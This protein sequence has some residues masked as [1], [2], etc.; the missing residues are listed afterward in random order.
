MLEL[1]SETTKPELDVCAVRLE[2]RARQ[3]VKLVCQPSRA[4][5]WLFLGLLN[6]VDEDLV[7]ELRQPNQ[8]RPFT[9]SPV[10]TAST[11]RNGPLNLEQGQTC[12]LRF[13][14]LTTRLKQALNKLALPSSV[15]LDDLEFEPVALHWEGEYASQTN[16][17]TLLDRHFFDGNND[18]TGRPSNLFRLRFL[19]P[20][21]FRLSG[22]EL[23]LPLPELIFGSL[24]QRW[25]RFSP[26]PL[27]DDAHIFAAHN[28]KLDYARIETFASELDNQRL[29]GFVGRVTFRAT[30]QDRFYLQT[31]QTLCDYSFYAGCGYKTT[32]GFGQVEPLE[33]I[34]K[35]RHLHQN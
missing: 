5:Y 17:R 10:M 6:L 13:T 18:T 27:P 29:I 21:L 23:A 32:A 15:L 30:S 9:V 1:P 26:G 20:T 19:S 7:E 8:L 12:Y 2:L 14:T 4:V 11:P 31:L 16:Y 35:T 34:S 28:L 33:Q 22:Q 25:N 24:L 3:A